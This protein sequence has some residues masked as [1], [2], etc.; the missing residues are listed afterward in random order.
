MIDMDQDQNVLSQAEMLLHL[1]DSFPGRIEVKDLSGSVLYANGSSCNGASS[2]LDEEKEEPASP[3]LSSSRTTPKS[4]APCLQFPVKDAKGKVIASCFYDFASS[5]LDRNTTESSTSASNNLTDAPKTCEKDTNN[6]T[7]NNSTNL[8]LHHN[9]QQNQDTAIAIQEVVTNDAGDQPVDCLLLQV[10][11]AFE[12]L[13]GVSDVTGKRLTQVLPG[14]QDDAARWIELF[15]TV[16]LRGGSHKFTQF[17]ETLQNWYSGVVYQ[18]QPNQFAVLFLE[19]T[20]HFAAQTRVLQESEERHRNLFECM[21]QGV[22]YQEASGTIIAANP[23]A[24]RILGL[25]VDQ[26]MGR[27]SVDPRWKSVREDGSDFP[28]HEHPSMQALQSGQPVVDAIMGVYHP[29]DPERHWIKIDAIPRFRAGETKP[30]QVYATFTDITDTKRFEQRLLNAKRKAEESDQLKSAFLANMSHE[31]RTPLNG[32]MGHIDLAL[33][34]NLSEKWRN[35]NLEGLQI[36]KTSGALL[37]S[38]IQ[39]ILDLSKIEA[40]QMIVN[41]SES[42]SLQDT[43]SQTTS[44][45]NTL[46]V[47]KQKTITFSAIIMDHTVATTSSIIQDKVLGD[48][49]RLQQVVNNLVSNAIKFTSVG[50]VELRIKL[51]LENNQLEFSLLDTGKGIPA[52]HIE[53]IFEPFRQVEIGDTRVF[54]GTGLG[55]TI[56]RKLVEMMG[57][58]LRLE[59]SVL[60]P[61]R[62]SMFAFTIPYRPCPTNNNIRPPKNDSLV[63]NTVSNGDGAT[64]LPSAVAPLQSNRHDRDGKG[65]ILV[66]EDDPVSRKLV[67]RMLQR[68]GY[69][70]LLACDGREAVTQYQEHKQDVVLILMDVQMPRLSGH[71]A[72]KEIRDHEK[73][74]SVTPVPIIG[75][76]AGAMKGDHEKG[77]SFGMTDYLT[78]PVDFK[79]LVKT[80]GTHLG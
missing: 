44:L 77:L 16:G 45:A 22:V 52:S 78:K 53:S 74:N 34:N 39:D 32:I 66:A 75:L 35:E 11:P 41:D 72:T 70:V 57:G 1:F 17:S 31:I 80:L 58:T 30:Y 15:G 65:K 38:I 51:L 7:N 24:E 60:G 63:P 61:I 73:A 18:T 48:P 54:G 56:S 71:E 27:T 28:G 33:S 29:E 20:D 64:L 50:K 25:T 14:I 3:V 46:I 6:I 79:N 4:P 76:S 8:L 69:N 21:M 43:M 13:V 59:S 37:I 5:V 19:T 26:M 9:M 2:P 62:G 40:G 10:N 47:S 36:S 67:S 68:T 49:F 23:A 55:L 42:F 12:R